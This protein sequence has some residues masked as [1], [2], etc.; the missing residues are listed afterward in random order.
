M[1]DTAIADLAA[2]AD[3]ERRPDHR[4]V[5]VDLDRRVADAFLEV[6]QQ[7]SRAAANSVQ[8][9]W[10]RPLPLARVPVAVTRPSG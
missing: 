10:R 4:D 9:C 2:D 6:R 8:L 1:I 3:D 7:A 5:A